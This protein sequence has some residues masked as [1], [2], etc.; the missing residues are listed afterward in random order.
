MGARADMRGGRQAPADLARRDRSAEIFHP[1]FEPLWPY[2][3]YRARGSVTGD[4]VAEVLT[5]LWT[6]LVAVPRASE[7]PW[8]LPE[9]EAVDPGEST[10]RK[11]PAVC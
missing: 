10:S 5:V 2:V 9:P 3:L 7:L 6:L 1:V 11:F 8:V 4:I